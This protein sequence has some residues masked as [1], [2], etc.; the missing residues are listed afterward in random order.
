MVEEDR[1]RVAVVDEIGELVFDIAVVD[2]AVRRAAL[3]RGELGLDVLVPV[4]ERDRHVVARADADGFEA[5]RDSRRAVVE[6]GPAAR[7]IA[8]MDREPVAVPIGNDF[9]GGRE[10]EGHGR[11]SLVGST[12]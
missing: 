9:P 5:R 2:V 12:R 1:L 6:L 4:V 8:G 10:V 3:H 7:D 11:G